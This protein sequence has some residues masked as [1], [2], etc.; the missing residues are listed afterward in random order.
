MGT[1]RLNYSVVLDKDGEDYSTVDAAAFESFNA[2]ILGLGEIS[3]ES[4]YH[5]A[6]AAIF[7][8][9]GF[10]PFCSQI[11]PHLVVPEYLESFLTWLFKK[12]STEFKAADHGGKVWLWCPL[13]FFAKFLGDGVLF[14][15]D[16]KSISKTDL[17]N[18]V[19]SLKAICD[20]YR[21]EFL[22]KVQDRFVKLPPRLRCG[23]ARGQV[24]S[25]GE[26]ADFVGPCINMAARLQ[27]LEEY[28]FAFSRRGFDLK[29]NF[30]PVWEKRFVAKKI[31]IRGISDQE[32]V[33]VPAKEASNR[34]GE[35]R[36]RVRR[37]RSKAK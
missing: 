32:V 30:H 33:Y 19:V 8:L 35:T 10:T 17:G 14:L 1:L 27:K 2:G 9:E 37:R 12:V 6:M 25:V 21:K 18:I 16:T 31:E 29:R 15:W 26:K 3:R 36:S 28:S 5:E 11:D 22:P 24:V 7:D 34:A 4:E 20:A 23:I 13:P